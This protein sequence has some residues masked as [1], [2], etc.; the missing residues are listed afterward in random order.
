[1]RMHVQIIPC[2][3]IYVVCKPFV[4]V[5]HRSGH[6][7]DSTGFEPLNNAIV[8]TERICSVSV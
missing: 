6:M 7:N 2:D 3:R 5:T 4:K 1:M 8:D